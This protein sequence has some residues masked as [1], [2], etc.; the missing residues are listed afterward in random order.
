MPK[1]SALPA[2]TPDSGVTA[3]TYT[4]NAQHRRQHLVR[5]RSLRISRSSV[6]EAN[7]SSVV[8]FFLVMT[9][10]PVSHLRARSLWAVLDYES[11]RAG[12]DHRNSKPHH[13]AA[14]VW[15]YL[16]RGAID[17]IPRQSHSALSVEP[18]RVLSSDR[19]GSDLQRSAALWNTPE[20]C[21]LPNAVR[22]CGGTSESH[23]D[24]SQVPAQ[25]QAPNIDRRAKHCDHRRDRTAAIIYAL[26]A[27]NSLAAWER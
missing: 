1:L 23:R 2:D 18:G 12:Q 9:A 20:L 14:G 19:S 10:G 6:N 21:S 15:R 22:R 7:Q 24:L 5:R 11:L 25:A 3:A 27:S 26:S 8:L 4:I 13:D 17:G 16:Y